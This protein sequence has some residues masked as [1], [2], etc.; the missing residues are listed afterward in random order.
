MAAATLV[1]SLEL[2]CSLGGLWGRRRLGQHLHVQIGRGER[3]LGGRVQEAEVNSGL[4][5]PTR[6]RQLVRGLAWGALEGAVRKCAHLHG[7]SK[8]AAACGERDCHGSRLSL[9]DGP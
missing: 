7:C 3:V 1:Y 5:A 8:N 9:Q 2:A 6:Q 4:L